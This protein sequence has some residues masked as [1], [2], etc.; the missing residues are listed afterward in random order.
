MPRAL[1]CIVEVTASPQIASPRWAFCSV[2]GLEGLLE[3][4]D[5]LDLEGRIDLQACALLGRNGQ[6]EHRH[7]NQCNPAS[8][9]N[10]IA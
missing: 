3:V 9:A 1:S 7:C 4:V 10:V 8:H 6:S 5:V 2:L